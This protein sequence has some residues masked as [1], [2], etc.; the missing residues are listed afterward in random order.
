[1]IPKPSSCQGCP[2]Y[3]E[4]AEGFVPDEIRDSAPVGIWMQNPGQDEI[5]Q[6]RPAVGKTGQEQDFNI[7][8]KAGL[9]REGVSIFNAI[10]CRFP[11]TNE[12]PELSTPGTRKKMLAAISHCTQAHWKRPAGLKVIVATGAYGLAAAS[13]G[14][15]WEVESWRGWAIPL[16]GDGQYRH[17]IWTPTSFD[18]PVLSTYHTARLFRE[19]D[20]RSITLMDWSKVARILRGTWPNKLPELRRIPLLTW[21]LYFSFDTE[22]DPQGHLTRYSMAD[23][24]LNTT[25]VEAMEHVQPW[26]ELGQTT[27]TMQNAPAD[28]GHFLDLTGIGYNVAKHDLTIDD[29]ML[30]HSVLWPGWPHSLE[31][32]GSLYS[33]LNRWKHLS[34]T[35]PIIY[36][37]ADAYGTMEIDQRLRA[38]MK[39]DPKSEWIYKECVRPHVWTIER[40]MREGMRTY[41]PNVQHFQTALEAQRDE[42]VLMAQAAVGWPI[43][44]GSPGAKGQVGHWLY[45]I[46]G[47]K[48]RG[49]RR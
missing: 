8:P 3:A 5:E 19:P 34:R 32:I 9:D 15:E 12:V 1:M 22:F 23:K 45:E 20:L 27:V 6:A 25:V 10:R 40:A 16:W 24:E 30:M 14:K 7:L 47:I 28:L 38:E 43:N 39:A 13:A 49:R 42:A 31:F 4:T 11:G 37:G 36:S 18:V 2:L 35:N 41:A 26:V 44:L 29:I 48:P 17:D 33:R 21:P 46:M